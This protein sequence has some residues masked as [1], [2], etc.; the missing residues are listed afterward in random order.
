M[1]VFAVQ[2]KLYWDDLLFGK[3]VIYCKRHSIER[4][5]VN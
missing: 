4:W 5:D 2:R 1:L 3:D